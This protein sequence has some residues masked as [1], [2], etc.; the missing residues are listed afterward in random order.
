MS[1]IDNYE[2]KKE[3]EKSMNEIKKR[4]MKAK[5]VLLA[6]EVGAGKAFSKEDAIKFLKDLEIYRTC[7]IMIKS[8]ES[9][10]VY[11]SKIVIYMGNVGKNKDFYLFSDGRSKIVI[12]RNDLL[13]GKYLLQY[14]LDE[15][16]DKK[17]YQ[18]KMKKERENR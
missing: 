16:R 11:N 13:Q 18:D 3:Q 5:P 15:E 2:L 1:V 4:I 12:S 14:G 6:H 9:Q 8:V 10:Y 7:C 17:I